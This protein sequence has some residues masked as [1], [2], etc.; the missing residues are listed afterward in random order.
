MSE[1]PAFNIGFFGMTLLCFGASTRTLGFSVGSQ[2]SNL[3]ETSAYFIGAIAAAALM[4]FAA[5]VFQPNRHG[6]IQPWKDY[7]FTE[8]IVMLLLLIFTTSTVLKGVDSL[9]PANF[10]T[11][12]NGE[13]INYGNAGSLFILLFTVSLIVT[14]GYIVDKNLRYCFHSKDFKPKSE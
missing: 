4:L 10:L 5:Q 11:D 13:L 12:E 7:S 2:F 6:V 1:Q 8:S 9:L 3:P 14:V